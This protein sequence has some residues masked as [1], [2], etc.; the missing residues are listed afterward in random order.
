LAAGSGLQ[1]RA[2]C[3]NEAAENGQMRRI[4]A[5]LGLGDEVEAFIGSEEW[6]D[7][8]PG[9]RVP[10]GDRLLGRPEE[11]APLSGFAWE[12]DD[13]GGDV[14][15]LY[16]ETAVDASEVDGCGGRSRLA[17]HLQPQRR[18][19]DSRPAR[20]ARRKRFGMP[21]DRKPGELFR[22]DVRPKSPWR[23]ASRADLDV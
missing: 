14:S 16:Y 22:H 4:A 10:A 8:L 18:R 5:P 23:T 13:P 9:L 6:V 7:L 1:L 11:V 2:Y 15:M 12:V 3:Y 19:G 21:A 17:P 20:L